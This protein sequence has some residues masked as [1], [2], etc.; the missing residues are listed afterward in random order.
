M[1]SD[2]VIITAAIVGAER[3]VEQCAALPITPEQL[4]DAAVE[5][6]EAGASIIHLHVRDEDGQPSQ[7]V[8][9]FSKVTDLIR[10][11]CDA[12]IQYST[13]G[14]VGTTTQ[15]RIAP[16]VLAP[17][18][19]TLSLGTLNFGEDIFENGHDT[20][21]EIAQGLRLNNVVPE[22]EIF[23][24]G[25]METLERYLAQELIPKKFHVDFVLGVPGG[26][27]G[28]IE[29][30]VTLVGRLPKGQSWSAAGLGRYELPLTLHALAMGG[31]VRV[32]LEDNIYYRKGELAKSNAQLIERVVR[33]AKECDRPIATVEQARQMLLA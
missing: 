27:S 5:S 4:V 7:R 14:A 33:I 8:D 20:I 29:N 6:V 26:L 10:Q 28:T 25:M 22:V 31:H 13:G 16:L 32:G 1:T 17:E 3:S 18:M 19:G 15:D 21:I 9:I 30:L 11:R 23:D 2:P 12:I 24:L